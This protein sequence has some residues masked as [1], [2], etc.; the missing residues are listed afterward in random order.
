MFKERH[1]I[2]WWWEFSFEVC[3]IRSNLTINFRSTMR[4][5]GSTSG[6]PIFGFRK[7]FS[8]IYRLLLLIFQIFDISI[9][10]SFLTGDWVTASLH[11]CPG[12][13]SVFWPIYAVVWMVSI[14]HLISKSSPPLNQSNGNRFERTNYNWYNSHFHVPQFFHLPIKVQFF[15]L[16]F[17]FFQLYSVVS[18]DTKVHYSA[19]SLFLFIITRSGCQAEIRWCWCY[20]YY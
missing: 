2:I 15:F 19:I 14:R 6:C 7:N 5:N 11:E 18:R 8:N 20:C 1:K 13:F 17:T 12:L 9:C 3:R 4:F 16:L 10:R